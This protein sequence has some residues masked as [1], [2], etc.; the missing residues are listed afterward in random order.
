M[1]PVDE[2]ASILRQVH[3]LIAAGEPD[4]AEINDLTTRA[5]V[6]WRELTDVEKDKMNLL[7]ASLAAR[8][9]KK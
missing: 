3:A 6:L 4:S 9:E 7:D 5:Q 8:G 2:Y 1:R